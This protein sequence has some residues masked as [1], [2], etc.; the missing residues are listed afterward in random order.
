MAASIKHR[1]WKWSTADTDNPAL[2]AVLGNDSKSLHICTAGD[3]DT[4]WNVSADSNPAVYIHSETTP[5][6]DYLVVGRHTGTEADIDLVGGTTL[7]LK[8]N[9]TAV[10]TLTSSL[11]T[12]PLA[13]Y[14]TMG[15]SA[16]VTGSGV[17]LTAAKPVAMGVYAEDGNAALSSAVLSRAGRFRN[18]QVYTGGNREQE[19]VGLIGQIVS[20]AGTN[21]H[22]MAGLMGSYEGSGALIVDG[23]A[24]ATDPWCQAAVIGRVGV[25]S[26]ITTINANGK[27]AG[28]AAM[29]NTASFLAN[30]GVYAGLY[31]GRWGSN[32]DWGYG[33]FMEN[34]SIGITLTATGDGAVVT[35]STLDPVT[36]RV[37]KF[38]GT[39]AAPNMA[40][41]Y[42]AFEVDFTLSGTMG[43]T[44]F[45]S[46]SSSWVNI[47]TGTVGAGK[48][49]CARN[50]G[51]YEA[52]AATIT[53]ALIIF[54][55]RMHKLLD[56]TDALS[57]PWSLNTNNTAI[58]ALFD[59]QNFTDFGTVANAGSSAATLVPFARNPAGT[60]KYVL[61]YDL[62]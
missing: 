8:I 47:P 57:F 17:I 3:A 50:D 36:G 23:Q 9:G 10:A 48:R 19:A 39:M 44:G 43:S 37:G 5:A 28:L 29:S 27:L 54:G 20:V 26:G 56:D 60:L 62:A 30:N 32:L 12:L 13:M 1:G 18:L 45:A 41:G 22:N 59:C 58:T 52:N 14:S 46:A 51:V 38:Y 61:L 42:G 40:D 6:T 25:G 53:N 11:F 49:V 55:A 2:V 4:D 16:S 15:A 21:R 31:V 7:N 35:S 33:I 24:S 34:V